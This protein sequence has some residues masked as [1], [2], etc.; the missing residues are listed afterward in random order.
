MCERE[1]PGMKCLTVN[2]SENLRCWLSICCMQCT[3][4]PFPTSIVSITNERML[5]MTQVHADLMGPSGSQ[6]TGD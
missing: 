4:G 1:H 2:V 5:I 6:L 3:D